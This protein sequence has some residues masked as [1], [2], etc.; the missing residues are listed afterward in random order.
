MKRIG[1]FL[2]PLLISSASLAQSTDEVDK[3]PQSAI[4]NSLKSVDIEVKEVG[5]TPISELH[6]VEASSGEIF[7]VTEDGKYLIVGN[8]YKIENGNVENLTLNRLSEQRREMIAEASQTINFTTSDKPEHVVY[9]FTDVDCGY[10][11]VLHDKISEYNDAGIEIRYLAFPRAGS[12]SE[13][14]RKME[15]AWCA[16]D[17]QASITLLKNGSNI[18]ISSCEN[19][20]ADHFELGQKMQISGT[21][22]LILESGNILPGYVP[23]EELKNLLEQTTNEDEA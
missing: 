14:W 3:N 18:R 15:S 5:D 6:E 2:I 16:D 1:L 10:C 7:Y 11:R 8:M 23:P 12:E 19:P 9:V 20:V 4:H 17:P 22:A 21:P 13:T